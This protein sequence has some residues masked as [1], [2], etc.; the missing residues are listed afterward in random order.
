MRVRYYAAANQLLI[1]L[2][3]SGVFTIVL[4]SCRR[5]SEELPVIP[6][7][8][9]PLSREYIGYGVVNVSFTHFLDESGPTGVSLGY[10][11]RGTVVRIIERR[12]IVSSGSE[13]TWV[14]MEGNY[15]GQGSVA[16]GWLPETA[17]II[18]DSESR[19]NT[20]SRTM[21]Q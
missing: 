12:H 15:Q 2:L 9:H 20:A 4:S 16:T 1:L 10:L 14:F 6:P 3:L 21:S 19:A 17:L 11:R 8:T 13:E 5:G 7:V 18:Y